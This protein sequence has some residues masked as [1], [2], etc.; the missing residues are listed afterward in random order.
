MYSRSKTK[1]KKF[2]LFDENDHLLLFTYLN[3]CIYCINIHIY[4]EIRL[5]LQLS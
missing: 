3:A 4:Q 2:G 1:N 5:I